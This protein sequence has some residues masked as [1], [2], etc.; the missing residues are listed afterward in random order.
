MFKFKLVKPF[1]SFKYCL[2][3]NN[4]TKNMWSMALR[5]PAYIILMLLFL[6]I[7]LYQC[8]NIYKL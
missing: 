7:I 5:D 8:I 2:N 4:T 6:G 3:F 1:S